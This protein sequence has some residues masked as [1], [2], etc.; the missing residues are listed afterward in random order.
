MPERDTGASPFE[1]HAPSL[2]PARRAE[3]R[4]RPAALSLATACAMLAGSPLLGCGSSKFAAIPIEGVES[5]VAFDE[6]PPAALASLRA[7]AGQ[8]PLTTIERED[9]GRYTAY[10]AE[11]MDNGREAEATVLADGTVLESEIEL[12][13]AEERAAGGVPAEVLERVE[14]LRARG[15]DVSVA[16]RSLFLYDIDAY[17]AEG[18]D[19][20]ELLL[21]PD[22]SDARGR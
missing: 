4:P 14:S 6:V 8:N 18:G 12:D 20:V 10:E 22:G 11:W 1:Q 16:R 5:P 15:Y 19:R 9:R 3:A 17:P 7:L 13:P 21:R 2:R